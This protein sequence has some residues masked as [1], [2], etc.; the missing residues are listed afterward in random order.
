[1][2]PSHLIHGSCA[3]WNGDG[4]LLLGPPGSGKSDLL[5][6]LLGRG[7][8][9]VADDQVQLDA[10]ADGLLASA[11]PRLAGMVEARGLG[12]LGGLATAAAPLRLVAELAAEVPRL[13]EPR[14][15]AGFGVS[16]PAM[17]LR[18]FE[19]SAPDKLEHALA[20]LRGRLTMTAGAFAA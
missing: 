19:A 7:W 1:M 2:P 3:A 10:A 15:W 11:P 18:P 16:I 20:V 9:L 12:I 13:P 8:A 6:R 4:V 14:P 17:P 5:L